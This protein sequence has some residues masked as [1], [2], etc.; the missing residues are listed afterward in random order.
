MS[1]NETPIWGPLKNRNQWGPSHLVFP[2]LPLVGDLRKL[3]PFS[4]KMTK[5]NLGPHSTTNLLH[6]IHF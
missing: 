2:N 3:H 1:M 4:L 6:N 5:A